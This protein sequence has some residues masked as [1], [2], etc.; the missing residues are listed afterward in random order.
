M[1]PGGQVMRP[2]THE[3]TPSEFW[4]VFWASCYIFR[5]HSSTLFTAPPSSSLN[6]NPTLGDSASFSSLSGLVRSV[7]IPPTS[8]TTLQAITS[9]AIKRISRWFS[10]GICSGG[11]WTGPRQDSINIR[12]ISVKRKRPKFKQVGH[13]LACP[14]TKRIWKGSVRFLDGRRNLYF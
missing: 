14:L 4:A 9:V 6:G 8:R 3:R 12:T 10:V 5:P 13:I 11:S 1:K 7:A 2:A